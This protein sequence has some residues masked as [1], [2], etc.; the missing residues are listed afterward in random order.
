MSPEVKE[1][2]WGGGARELDSEGHRDSTPSSPILSRVCCWSPE[3]RGGGG[4]LKNSK[5]HFTPRSC[6]HS[7]IT[8][9]LVGKRKER[10][11]SMLI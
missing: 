9:Q 3:S 8:M 10:F 7:E 11:I 5:I 2:R 4:L 1:Q 6:S